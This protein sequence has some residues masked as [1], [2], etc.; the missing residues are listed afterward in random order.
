[1]PTPIRVV[2]A[3]ANKNFRKIISDLL[4]D[5]GLDVLEA[6]DG[7]AVLVAAHAFLPRVV[8]LDTKVR[9]PSAF[10]VIRKLRDASVRCQAI[11]IGTYIDDGMREAAVALGVTHVF[12]KPFTLDALLAA[13]RKVE[14]P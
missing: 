14:Q 4:R 7:N 6:A 13:I 1:M 2:V 5:E 10:D 12:E 3:D 8:V 9:D 11:L